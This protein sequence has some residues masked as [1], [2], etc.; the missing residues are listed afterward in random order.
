MGANCNGCGVCCLVEPCPLGVVLSGRRTG[1][2]VAL[3]WEDAQERYFCGA[4][5]QASSVLRQTLP[6][7]LR[8]LAPIL[9]P[10]VARLSW[11]WIA[12]GKGCDCSL[13]VE[14]ARQSAGQSPV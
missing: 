6:R 11:R 14:P 8:I 2:C 9:G 10:T 13:E 3:R 5:T 1:A 12:A 4:V 7:G